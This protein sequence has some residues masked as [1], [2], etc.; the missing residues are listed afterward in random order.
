[1]GI[2]VQKINYKV[3]KSATDCGFKLQKNSKIKK[4]Y[5]YLQQATFSCIII[6]EEQ[7]TKD[8]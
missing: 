4:V 5:Q 8:N 1:M 7:H 6:W 2:V 3:D